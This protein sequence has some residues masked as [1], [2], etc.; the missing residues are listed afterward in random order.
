MSLI[1]ILAHPF[2]SSKRKMSNGVAHIG[3]GLSRSVANGRAGISGWASGQRAIRTLQKDAR[4]FRKR[5]L[6]DDKQVLHAI[7]SMHKHAHHLKKYDEQY[8][9]KI[10][11]KW[12]DQPTI[13]HK[14]LSH[15]VSGF[16]AD[17]DGFQKNFREFL[18]RVNDMLVKEAQELADENSSLV[19][20]LQGFVKDV[21]RRE[22][23]VPEQTIKGAKKRLHKLLEHKLKGYQREAR[24]D[25]K[26]ESNK[27]I[28]LFLVKGSR[29]MHKAKKMLLKIDHKK[30]QDLRQALRRMRE[31]L[32]NGVE[33]DF[34]SLFEQ[35]LK[36]LELLEKYYL[37]L[38]HDIT[39][40]ILST[41][42][43]LDSSSQAIALFYGMF[44][45]DPTVA[46]SQLPKKLQELEQDANNVTRVLETD[47]LDA[48]RL[49]QQ[50]HALDSRLAGIFS[51][52]S[53][54]SRRVKEKIQH[55]PEQ[56]LVRA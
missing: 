23:L 26:V 25:R 6:L 8:L 32:N 12:S 18:M 22:M 20:L 30:Q 51:E 13:L 39:L 19:N 43:E 42:R 50:V 27:K 53:H 1:G 31:E 5:E 44:R 45:N 33:Q 29:A 34:L 9:S 38:H 40:T 10:Q 52:L 3:D 46:S 17:V 11:E 35:H 56:L 4:T 49:Y 15:M 41:R 16:T 37:R 14:K 55:H 54:I 47:R 21:N 24:E 36:N 28:G 48:K 2:S 7:K